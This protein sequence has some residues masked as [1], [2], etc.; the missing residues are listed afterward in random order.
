MH[1][2]E[3]GMLTATDCPRG[4]VGAGATGT[5]RRP[6]AWVKGE[7]AVLE[8]RTIGAMSNPTEPTPP[9][10]DE[11]VG[12]AAAAE[13]RPRLS[14]PTPSHLFA[15]RT[16]GEGNGRR[17]ATRVIPELAAGSAAPPP[18]GPAEPA[19]RPRTRAG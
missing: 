15:E 17:R 3:W 2:T 4:V 1:V 9:A 6:L 8:T 7:G 13:R 19:P 16:D 5:S 10:S 11:P 14:R 12:P 18:D